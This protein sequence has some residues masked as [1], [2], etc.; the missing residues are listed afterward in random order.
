[1]TAESNKA[2]FINELVENPDN[3][4]QYHDVIIYLKIPWRRNDVDDDY[5]ILPHPRKWKELV[6]KAHEDTIH[7]GRKS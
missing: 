6:E 2:D 7:A 5:R 1:M 4:P 3:Y